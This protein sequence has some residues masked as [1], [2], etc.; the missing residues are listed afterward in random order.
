MAPTLQSPNVENYFVGKGVVAFKPDGNSDYHYVGNVPEF[1]FEPTLEQ[2]DHFSSQEGVREKDKTIVLEKG[3]T[4]RM[5]ME[6]LTARNLALFLLG[7]VDLT[8]PDNPEIDI[9]SK[10]AFSGALV[11]YGT[12]EVGPRWTF[13]FNKVDFIPSGSMNPISDEWGSVEVTGNLA[14]VGGSFGTAKMTNLRDDQ[15]PSNLGKP[16]VIGKTEVGQTLTAYEGVWTGNPTSYAYKWLADDV[17]IGGAT[18]RTYELT[19]SEEG[20]MIK[21]EVT[22]TNSVGAGSAVES[23]EVGPVVAA[24]T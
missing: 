3:G 6:E 12:N 8:D 23:P 16:E 20:A 7:D 14:T 9:F 4:V 17:E 19:A 2:L 18:S 1:E 15:V 24:V 22:P 5:V 10:N 11:F 13:E 21:C